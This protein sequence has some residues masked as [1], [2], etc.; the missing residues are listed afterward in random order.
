VT[1]RLTLCTALAFLVV[2]QGA[3]AGSAPDLG[4]AFEP[5]PKSQPLYGVKP[6][7]ADPGRQ[8]H[9]VT[10]VDGTDLYVETWLPA[11]KDGHTPP[12]HV[13]TV[14]IM[15]P[16]VQQ[17]EQR[18][19]DRNQANVIDWFT[20]R[21]YAVAQHHVRGTGQSG[22]CIEQTSTLQI[23]DGARVVEYLGRD[24][25]WSNGNVGMY[26]ISYDAETQISVAGRG[27]PN[28]TKYLKAIVPAESV[29]GQYE[30][31]N[32]DGVPWAGNAVLSNAAYLALT[33]LNPGTAPVDAHTFERF[34]CQPELFA[35]ALNPTGDLTPFWQVRE[36]RPE[37]KNFKAATLWLHG[38]AD[39]NVMPITV[40]GFFDRLP[41]STPHKGI[42]GIWEH[43]YPDKHA[44]VSP[45]W[46][47]ADLLPL[48]TAW[49]DRYLK[50]LPTKV[51]DWPPVQVQGSD[52]QWHVEGDWPRTGGP[53]GQLGLGPGGQL[54]AAAPSGSTSYVEGIDE[55][56][57]ISGTRAVFSTGKL[58]NRL[59][60]TGQ[61]VLDAWLTTSTGD[62]HVAARLQVVGPDGEVA[63]YDG[64]DQQEVATYGLR[65]LQH[66]DPMPDG[67]FVQ[68]HGTLA[69]IAT[70]IRVHVRF[71]PNDLVVPKGGQ[72][73][74]T[75][76]GALA[77]PRQSAPSGTAAQITILHDCQ[78]PSALRFLQPRNDAPLLNVRELD[79]RSRPAL[80]SAFDPVGELGTGTDATREALCGKPPER[81]PEL[82]EAS[83]FDWPKPCNSAPAPGVTR[84]RLTRRSALVRTV[85][86]ANDCGAGAAKARRVSVS[87][88]L[89]TRGRRCRFLTRRGRLGPPRRC[90]R[91]VYLRA[92]GGG[93]RYTLSIRRAR[94]R[95]GRY[96]VRVRAAYPKRTR[97]TTRRA[98]VR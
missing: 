67:Y 90:S 41:A 33:S 77:A 71:Q 36:Y 94:L 69:P 28:R 92:T 58:L 30:Y 52:G 37:A 48:V 81:I 24:A 40:A 39:W 91:P 20:A 78:H 96:V 31:S 62:G 68:Q 1:R 8:Q 63:R 53:V 97:T 49:Y 72:L 25:P 75:V 65:S 64:S 27:D 82:G 61:P 26:G 6:P 5:A 19:T 9:V 15:T 13:P 44:G 51:E 85:A 2:A 17:G 80:A 59:E 47:R 43:N 18:Y 76:A 45:D 73:R 10:G 34:G 22:G 7:S 79:E 89:R 93:T 42:F 84:L 14:L 74:L 3:H 60:I 16:Y 86:R 54:G 46:E 88:G 98:R 12:A 35:G 87:V 56:D 83:E 32:F 50:D 66:L 29:G 21:G 55:E 70:P 95:R 23:D 57:T 11:A 4:L 38:L